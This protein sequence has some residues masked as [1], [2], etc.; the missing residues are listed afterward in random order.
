LTSEFITL[1]FD[2][3]KSS[4]IGGCGSLHEISD[5]DRQF[6]GCGSMFGTDPNSILE[7]MFEVNPSLSE[8]D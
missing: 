5:I 1:L 2:Y 6:H 8:T 4:V 7:R 3:G